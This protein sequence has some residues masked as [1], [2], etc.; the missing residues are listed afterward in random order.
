[1]IEERYI[2]E[3]EIDLLLEAVF[4]RCGYDFRS[5]AR[6]S[7]ERRIRQ[8]MSKT[9]FNVISEMIPEAL[10]DLT[11]LSELIQCFS[12]SVTD[13][14]RDPYV[15]SAIR[16]KVVPILKTYPHVKVW[17]AGCATGEEVYSMAV[18]LTEEGLY[19]RASLFGTDFNEKALTRAKEGI[20]PISKLKE[21]TQNYQQ[22]GGTS[23]FGNYYHAN[24]DSA[25]MKSFLKK[26]ITFAGHNLVTDSVFGEMHLVLCRNVLIYFNK[27]LQERVLRLFTDSLVRG[28]ILCLGNK[29]DLLFTEVRDEYETVDEKAKIFKKKVL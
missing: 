1:M 27:N 6:A 12:I 3:I 16:E 2:E 17:H 8:H 22:A 23:S 10:R 29:E 26:R 19:E 5:Y 24:Y 15:Y 18:L 4:Q 9:S 21:F 28:G 11:F 14:F 25:V 7:I 13:M 20:Y